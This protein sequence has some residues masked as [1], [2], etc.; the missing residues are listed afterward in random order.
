MAR[1]RDCRGWPVMAKQCSTCVFKTDENGRYI[2]K[3]LAKRVENRLLTVSQI[4]HHPAL[5]GQKQTHLCRGTRDRQI[6]LMHRMGVIAAPTDEAWAA[7][8][9]ELGI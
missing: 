9:K 5:K 2:Y 4:C 6:T 7:K 8:Q 3:D 1:A